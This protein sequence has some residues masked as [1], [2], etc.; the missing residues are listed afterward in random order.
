MECMS[1]AIR[2]RSLVISKDAP[3]SG[4]WSD[5]SEVKKVEGMDIEDSKSYIFPVDEV[6]EEG[7]NISFCCIGEKEENISSLYFR[8]QTYSTGRSQR[9]MV[10]T[11]KKIPLSEPGGAA[12]NCEHSERLWTTVFVTRPPGAPKDLS[13]E[14]EDMEKLKCTWQPGSADNLAGK[15][16]IEFILSDT[17][18]GK[19]NCDPRSPKNSCSFEIGAQTTYGLRLEAKNKLGTKFTSLNFDVAH[20]VHPV[21]PFG[22]SI[23]GKSATT[24]ELFWKMR[25]KLELLCQI[26]SRHP[27]GKVDLHNST[28]YS[29]ASLHTVSGLEPYTEYTF[30]VRC[31][32]NRHF[33]KWSEWSKPRTERTEESAP[34]G[35]LDIWRNISPGLDSCNVTVFWKPFPAFRANGKIKAYEIFWEALGEHPASKEVPASVNFTMLFLDHCSCNI[36]IWAKNSLKTLSPSVIAISAVS[37][38]DHVWEINASASKEDTTNNTETGIYISWKPQSQFDGYV[39]DWCNHPRARPCDFQ[40]KKFGSNQSSGL[41]TSDA[42][43]PGVQYSFRVFGSHDG[44]A[45]LLEKKAKYLKELEPA[46]FPAVRVE[47]ANSRLL[48]LAWDYEHLNESHPGFIRGYRVLVK[49]KHGNCTLEGSEKLVIRVNAADWV[50]CKYTISEPATK[51]LTVRH[52]GLDKEYWLEVLAF[53]TS[54]PNTTDN[55]IQ[56]TA[57]HIMHVPISPDGSWTFQ[58]LQIPLGIS[59]MLLICICFWRSSC[60]R[61]RCCPQIPHPIVTPIKVLQMYPKS[62]LAPSD[63]APNNL[64]VEEQKSQPWSC[65][66]KHHYYNQG[67][68]A[69]MPAVEMLV[70]QNITYFSDCSSCYQNL[71]PQEAAGQRP[72]LALASHKPLQRSTPLNSLTNLNYVSQT[73]LSFLGVTQGDR[74]GPV[75]SDRRVDYKPQQV[76]G[77]ES[78]SPDTSEETIERL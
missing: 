9:R 22:L 7:S 35:P 71:P 43:I 53:S 38:N 26:E 51:R 63:L 19:I 77:S 61:N 58:S 55:I 68:L 74:T 4:S 29:I 64:L 44:T 17:S 28:S 20:R 37:E 66:E 76:W 56:G 48:K 67:V 52:P 57:P 49:E 27:D 41:I 32:A 54:P 6:V 10:F 25:H 42:F 62:L 46:N 60:T 30:R 12:V 24:I 15:H 8:N 47:T 69:E 39:V 14:T 1:Y 23:V 75:S 3:G 59:A 11:I 5:W 40:W 16:S 13:C 70:V 18:N 78:R 2:I 73:D 72:G 50:I 45:S 21:A 31:G 65:E 33:W 36:S 34:S